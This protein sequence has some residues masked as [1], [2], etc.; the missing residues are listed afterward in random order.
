VAFK[1]KPADW[2]YISA[3][4][5][6]W[7]PKWVPNLYLGLDRSFIVYRND[8]GNKFGDYFPLFS[9]LDKAA[10][11][12]PDLSNGKNSDDL[13]KRDQ[14]AS[15]SAR[16]AMPESKAEVYVQ[17]GRNDHPYDLRDLTTQPEHS[18]AY[19]AGFR[20]L[21][22]LRKANEYIQVGLE[23]TQTE[24]STTRTVRAGE[25][26]YSHYQVLHGYTNRGQV[27]GAGIGP[28]SN[29]QSLDVSWVK[30]LQ[31][32]GLQLERRVNNND[33][34]YASGAYD[35][36][37]HWVDLAFS[38]RYD[39]TYK[40]FIFNFGLT[41]VKSLNYQYALQPGETFWNWNKQDANNLSLRAGLLYRW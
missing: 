22:P 12:D 17:Y 10:Y 9:A 6:T 7:Q 19:V 40:Q 25:T 18:R 24:K 33:F 31:R 30:G 3:L 32:I 34:L 5:V 27:I 4:T 2:R 1:N 35:I 38:G 26:W 29:L 21:L 14:Y 23:V 28:G 11:G 13:A 36:R 37:K 20:K 39:A 41:Y 16:W 8:M 15:L